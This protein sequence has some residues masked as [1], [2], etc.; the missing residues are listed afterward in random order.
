[1]RNSTVRSVRGVL[2]GVIV[3]GVLTVSLPLIVVAERVR[4]GSGRS[5]AARATRVVAA[6][7]GLAFDVRGLEQLNGSTP[8]VFVPN[9]SS[10]A[11]IPAMLAA[12]SDARFLAAAELFRI[13]LLGWA[14]RAMGSVPINRSRPRDAQRQLDGTPSE[15]S[16]VVFA[17]GGIPAE[18]ERVR[19]KTGAFVLAIETR[20][21]VVPVSIHG[22]ADVLP[23]GRR[24]RVL[25][26]VV[27]VQLHEPIATT[28]MT[29]A[30]RKMLRDST[31]HAVREFETAGA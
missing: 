24:L 6:L 27:T 7:C 17:E 16:V 14:M 31:E 15:G 21:A 28:G 22:A 18:H 26:G 19:F 4:R 2:N 8:Y 30:D 25:P 13:P 10:P 20:R 23:R 9:H 1:M 29:L 5:V 11:D 12:V 3:A